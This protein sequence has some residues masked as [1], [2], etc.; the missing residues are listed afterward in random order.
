MR[1]LGKVAERAARH[2]LE[3]MLGVLWPPG[4]SAALVTEPGIRTVLFVQPNFRIGNT[5]IA[6][7]I[8]P[9]LRARFPGARLDCLVGDTTASL[10]DGQPIDQIHC[11]SRHFLLMP[12]RFVAL[13]VRLRRERFD[14]AVDGGM[15][16]YSG[17]L[18]AF[19]SGARQRVGFA[20]RGDRFLTT[21]FPSTRLVSAYD[22][23]EAFARALGVACPT[24]PRY[25]VRPEERAAAVATLSSLG[26]VRDGGVRPFVAAFVGGHLAKRWPERCW[27]DLV[28]RLH[29]AG[30]PLVI[31]LGPEEIGRAAALRAQTAPG[32]RVVPPQPL[33]AFAALLA[34]ATLLV[35]P[36]SGPMHLAAALGVPTV[37]VLQQQRSWFYVPR[38]SHDRALFRPDCSE[39]LAAMSENPRW[40]MLAPS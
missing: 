28:A 17:A 32:L 25:R 16:S 8:V 26:L 3:A 34:H 11:V 31:F 40:P 23:A 14:L 1:R 15:G 6:T 33:R 13:F 2:G 21:R 35:T 30:V 22:G 19:L 18:Y 27:S 9:V 10:L 7:A 4:E 39:V 12:W 38:G 20:V 36:D 5:M 24:G 29:G 37:A